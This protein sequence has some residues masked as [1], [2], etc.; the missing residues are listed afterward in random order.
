MEL[1]TYQQPFDR[2]VVLRIFDWRYSNVAES[3]DHLC[4]LHG[5]LHVIVMLIRGIEHRHGLW[6]EVHVMKCLVFDNA[7][8]RNSLDMEPPHI[9]IE[10]AGSRE[11]R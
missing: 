8:S 10:V 7:K 11:C 3:M 5:P 6:E 4:L 2:F 1:L 9:N